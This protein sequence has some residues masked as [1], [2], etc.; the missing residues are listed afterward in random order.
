MA[1][2]ICRM[3]V[4]NLSERAGN[5]QVF[6]T[7]VRSVWTVTRAGEYVPY[8]SY[9]AALSAD[10]RIICSEGHA[11]HALYQPACPVPVDNQLNGNERSF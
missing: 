9:S 5:I 7:R 8:G 11:Q 10:G 1:Q 4:I 3:L 6:R 2:H